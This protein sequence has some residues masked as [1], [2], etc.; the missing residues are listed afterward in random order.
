MLRKIF[1]ILFFLSICASL[2]AQ[3]DTTFFQ[4][5]NSGNVKG[6]D[7]RWKNPDGSYS[8]WYQ[9]NDRG[10]GDSIRATYKEDEKG[11][12]TWMKASGNDYMKNSIFEE[13]KMEGNRINYTNN[14]EKEEKQIDAPGYYLG[15]KAFV[16]DIYK[17][18]KKNN[19]RIKLFPYGEAKLDVLQEHSLKYPGKIKKVRL[20]AISGFGM[21]P[22]YTW[23]DENFH[24]FASVSTWNSSILKGYEKNIADL[25]VIQEKISASYFTNI[26]KKLATKTGSVVIGQVNLFDAVNARVIPDVDV[27]IRDGIIKEVSVGKRI[28]AKVDHYI[29]GK[30]KTILPGLW[31]M[32]VHFTSE[33]DGILHTAAGVTHVRDMGNDSTLLKRIQQIRTGEIIGPEVE[34]MSGFIDGAGPLAAPT[35]ALINNLDEGIAAIRKYAKQGYQQIKL[36]SSIKP[37]WVKPLADEAHKNNMRV[38]GH[39]P[40]FMIA[41]QAVA[42]GYDEITHMNMLALNFF[43]DTIDTRSPN[44]FRIPAQKTA[45]LD[46]NST[47][48]KNFIQLLKDKNI[49]VD[50]TL[51]VFESLFTA[52]DGKMEPR[53]NSIVDRFP[54]TIQRNIRAGGGGLPVPEGMDEIYLKSFDAFLKITKLLYD[55]GI[56]IVA[57]TDGFA[58]FDLHRELELYVKAGIPAEKVLQIATYG[59]AKYIGKQSSLGSIEVGRKADIILVEGNPV[60]NISDIRNTRWVIKGTST[61]DAKALYGGIAIGA[62]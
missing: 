1:W 49:A 22:N 3:T 44:R 18:M 30:G 42:A 23:L 13:F 35:G 14:A 19:N 34:I 40:A 36:Y 27:L 54:S 45:S 39:I 58:G 62:K 48:F 32:H 15:L 2:N 25:L 60:S 20:V 33:L 46:L 38:A 53:F 52:R 43:G 4:I 31:D 8:S 56:T 16:G 51:G 5:I 26:T 29:D 17:A 47:A 59:T 37:E 10:R 50:P 57:G 6:F 9:F 11:F 41:E 12:V 7:K 28:N 24:E 61:Y 21:T 55:N